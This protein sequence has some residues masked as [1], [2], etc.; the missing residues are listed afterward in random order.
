MK[1]V[2]ITDTHLG[3]R[4]DNKPI[5]SH[6]RKFYEKTFI[7]YLK[8][9]KITDILHLDDVFDR[10]TGINFDTLDQSKEFLF[11]PLAALGVNM[12]TIIG[13]HDAYYK[14]KNDVNSV[15]LLL[16]GYDNIHAYVEDPVELDF[17]GCKVGLVPWI[18]S[19]NYDKTYKFLKKTKAT[20][21]RGHFAISGFEMNKGSVCEDGMKAKTFKSF[22]LVMSGHFHHK[23]F[24]GNI[25]YLGS[26][27]QM[28]WYDYGDA[29]GFH[30]LD[31][32][33]RELEFVPN[34][35]DMFIKIMYD[36]TALR[37]DEVET[38]IS[39]SMEGSFIKV[40]VKNNDDKDKMSLLLEKLEK[41]GLGDYKIDDVTSVGLG[42]EEEDTVII[43]DIL[44]FLSQYVTTLDLDN[45]AAV[46]S[47]LVSLY[48]EAM[49]K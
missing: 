20:I 29:R 1:L 42:E 25:H 26:P 14:N 35:S 18:T 15:S 8:K 5:L 31:T 32:D 36:D 6:Q 38:L 30:V 17:D 41:S 16:S 34:P 7:P 4:Q 13:N 49:N 48:K 47:L 12:H 40:V 44:P 23:S 11:D 10:R 2:I 43:E 37:T 21:I 39:D 46:E 24:Q 22:E 3:C 9:H 33:T 28:A 19:S 45:K 27:Y